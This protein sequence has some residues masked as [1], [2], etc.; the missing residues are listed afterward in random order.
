MPY[1]HIAVEV[2]YLGV[3]LA[4]VGSGYL[5]ADLVLMSR[6]YLQTAVTELAVPSVLASTGSAAG[7]DDSNVVFAVFNGEIHNSGSRFND[8]PRQ[9]HSFIEIG[10]TKL[11]SCVHG[12]GD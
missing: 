11:L 12:S 7:V 3:V 1:L 2:A 6:D 8:M 9:T 5:V 4:A 10:L